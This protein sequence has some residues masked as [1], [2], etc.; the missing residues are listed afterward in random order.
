MDGELM[1]I[2]V[3]L[4]RDLGPKRFVGIEVGTVGSYAGFADGFFEWYHKLIGYHQP[5]RIARPKNTFA[6]TLEIGPTSFV[7]EPSSFGLDD[8]RLLG[9]IRYTDALQS[10]VSLSLPTATG[11]GGFGR[12][13][14]GLATVHTVRLRPLRSL[15]YE[16]TVGLGATPHHGPLSPWQRSLFVSGSTGIR[17][18][19]WGGQSVYGYYYFH[20]PYYHDTGLPSLDR[21]ELTGDFG[22]ISRGRDGREWRFGLGEDLQPGDPGIDLILK[23]GRTW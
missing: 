16:G 12:G 7:R 14:V 23:I 17:L 10:V 22:W 11:G 13:T 15:V 8:I 21:A 18:H 5:E 2:R 1:R 6:D 19:L 3:G 4:T 20:S 9:G